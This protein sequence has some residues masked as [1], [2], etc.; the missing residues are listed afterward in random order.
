MTQLFNDIMQS[1][2]E[3]S[4]E[5]FRKI[6][7]ANASNGIM[8]EAINCL[9]HMSRGSKVLRTVADILG[10]L[11]TSEDVNMRYLALET[12]THLAAIGDP[13]ESLGCYQS[14][15][16]LLLDDKDVS[17]KRQALD[18]L[19]SMCESRNVRQIVSDLLA[20][21]GRSDQEFR[22]EMILK[23]A[24]L[25]EKY[26]SEYTWYV[27]VMLQLIK[28]AGDDANEMIWHR[29]VHIVTNHEDVREYAAYTMMQALKLH[30][31]HEMAV[32]IGGYLLGEYGHFIVESPGCS[33]FEQFMALHSKFGLFSR[34]TKAILLTSYFKLVNLFPEIR[35]EII[36]VLE[37]FQYVL[38][39]ELQQRAC[40]YLS[41]IQLGDEDLLQTVCAE[42]PHFPERESILVNELRK[43]NNN[44]EDTRVFTI[45]GKD[46]QK[47]IN[48][49]DGKKIT[50]S[51]TVDNSAMRDLSATKK[52]SD[53]LLD[54]TQGGCEIH[55]E[56]ASN[57]Q[58]KKWLKNLRTL[59]NGVIY[60]DNIVQIG[61]KSGY[62]LNT[63][64]LTIFCGNKSG[65]ALENFKANI[66]SNLDVSFSLE[67]AFNSSIAAGAQ[68]QQVS[69]IECIGAMNGSIPL[70]ISFS[71][72]SKSIGIDL[73]APVS[74]CKFITPVTLA[75]S[76]FFARWGQIGG[77]PNE[78]QMMMRPPA[79]DIVALKSTIAGLQFQVLEG[80]DPIS[81]NIVAAGI[82]NSSSIG[83]VGCLLRI[84]SNM[85]H[86]VRVRF[87][88]RFIV[89][90]F[91]PQMK[92]YLLW[93]AHNYL[94]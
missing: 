35:K 14:T 56:P 32:R 36:R 28:L 60:E 45:G 49:I 46:A 63:G 30:D 13:L 23:I 84:E 31:C 19:Y 27:D 62:Q 58:V 89:S 21:L 57:T 86:Q 79:I 61:I 87:N 78:V 33:P 64:K 80:V 75:A 12:M 25:A 9:I 43:K 53:N 71:C 42:M 85:Q 73:I 3:T 82:F 83:K 88:S 11:L 29:V 65:V 72:S 68:M 20:Y 17:I 7:Q 69:S 66:D 6:Q 39:M 10:G 54:M 5:T 40:E 44:T 70:T 74:V 59:A 41:I 91:G 48:S 52:Q 51:N 81:E 16:T 24:I 77:P 37:N 8:L 76:D 26:V 38:D 1:I 50:P 22:E 34:A 15:I 2:L 55:Q 90:L 47:I 18:L 94:K 4:K 93:F 67:S 92:K